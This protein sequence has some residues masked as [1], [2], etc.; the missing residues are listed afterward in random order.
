MLHK[1]RVSVILL[2]FLDTIL[3]WKISV[4]DKEALS[5]KRER[6]NQPLPYIKE[7]ENL[8]VLL[9]HKHENIFPI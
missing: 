1:Y 7:L 8:D 5:M 4:S 6:D 3:D 9:G 2:T